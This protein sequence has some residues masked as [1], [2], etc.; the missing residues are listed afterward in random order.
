MIFLWQRIGVRKIRTYSMTNR[1]S[2]DKSSGS[3]TNRTK[4]NLMIKTKPICTKL[5]TANGT[6]IYQCPKCKYISTVPFH[7]CPECGR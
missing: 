5:Y 2:G 6:L 7:K 1:T 3:M 4:R